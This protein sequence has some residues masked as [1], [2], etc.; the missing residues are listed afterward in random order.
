MTGNIE[1]KKNIVTDEWN[2]NEDQGIAYSDRAGDLDHFEWSH[3]H[4]RQ[5]TW[6]VMEDLN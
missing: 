3:V 6:R 1:N 2:V 5:N 4:P